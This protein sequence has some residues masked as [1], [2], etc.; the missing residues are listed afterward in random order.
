[1]GSEP[2]CN[3]R[4]F[5]TLD[6]PCRRLISTTSHWKAIFIIKDS[7]CS[8][9]IS[10]LAASY[11]AETDNLQEHCQTILLRTQR[12]V[13]LNIIGSVPGRKIINKTWLSSA[14]VIYFYLKNVILIQGY[15]FSDFCLNIWLSE[16]MYLYC[17]ML[18]EL[19]SL[20]HRS[21]MS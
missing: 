8:P 1:M 2:F 21:N 13:T 7:L 17:S 6:F 15:A 10:I 18:S 12:G 5:F 4:P 19:D 11:S 3:Y 20:L 16:K 14:S 9:L